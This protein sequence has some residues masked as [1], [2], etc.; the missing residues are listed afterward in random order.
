MNILFQ[1]DTTLRESSDIVNSLVII[2]KGTKSNRGK[3][4][5]SSMCNTGVSTLVRIHL[6]R[7]CKHDDYIGILRYS[8]GHLRIDKA[9]F[10][11]QK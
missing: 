7:I 11:K 5:T 6:K 10:M 8:A 4:F 3:N 1:R 2:W 9:L